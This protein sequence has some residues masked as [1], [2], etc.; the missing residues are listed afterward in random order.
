MKTEITI[1]NGSGWNRYSALNELK[2]LQVGTRGLMTRNRIQAITVGP[3]DQERPYGIGVRYYAADGELIYTQNFAGDDS[4]SH[5]RQRIYS[6]LVEGIQNRIA[7]RAQDISRQAF[8]H[9]I[10]AWRRNWDAPDKRASRGDRLRN[11]IGQLRKKTGR[12]SRRYCW[13]LTQAVL[14]GEL[15]FKDAIAKFN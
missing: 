7:R 15:T 8:L 10:T 4:T 11:K 6:L 12:H 14:K 9:K 2:T 1:R 3:M 5:I 13:G